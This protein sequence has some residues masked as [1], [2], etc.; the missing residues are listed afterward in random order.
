MRAL[1]SIAILIAFISNDLSAAHFR[2]GGFL[3]EQGILDSI[4][5][6][7]RLPA[8]GESFTVRLSGSWP[9]AS[10][11]GYCYAPLTL[12]Q[13]IVYPGSF[14]KITSLPQHDPDYCDQPPASWSFDVP[15]PAS[16]WDAVD[17][18]GNL[19]ISHS[20]FT[21]INQ[22]TDINQVFDMRLG[23]HEIPAYIGSGFWISDELPNEGILI[24]QQGNRVLFYGLGYDRDIN[25]NDNGEPVWQLVAGEMY[26]NSTLGKS[27]RFDWPFD[28]NNMPLENPTETELITANDSGAI[29]VKGYNQIRVFT[30]THNN[31]GLYND[32]KRI[33]FGLD[34][35]RLPV[36]APP[37]DGVWTLYGFDGQTATFT[38]TMQLLQGSSQAPNQY[39]F[40]STGGDW[41]ATCN[42]V[43]AGTGDCIVQRAS[44]GAKFE[45]LMTDFQGNLAIGTLGIGESNTLDGVLVRDPWELP[46][47]ENQ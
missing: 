32:Y 43:S 23:T 2:E 29:I 19:L 26:G 47:L 45:F 15:I 16:A 5:I 34:K 25:L 46:V 44:D 1:F 42:V 7:P 27:Y 18:N 33:V 3:A 11:D 41:L 22:L 12:S 8:Q 14:V 31:R 9:A 36:Y 28:E 13:V 4:R 10:P 30:R 37:L 39:Q 21:G 20:L 40:A 17:E 6:E 38:T 35:S 24:E